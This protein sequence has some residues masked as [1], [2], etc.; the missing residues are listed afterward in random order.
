MKKVITIL[1]LAVL[2]CG[3]INAQEAAP[4]KKDMST[5]LKYKLTIDFISV[6]AGID[7]ES[8]AKIEEFIKSHPKKPAYTIKQ[9]GKE[10]ETKFL[11]RLN[12]LTK[13]EQS[14]FVADIK[15]L[16]TKPELVKISTTIITKMKPGTSE[17]V[18]PINNSY[19]LVMSFISKGGGIDKIHEKIME[20]VEKHPKKPAFET[21][22]WGR[23]GEVD[24]C[25]KLTELTAE[26]QKIFVKDIN[27]MIVDKEMVLVT[28]NQ[29]YVKKGR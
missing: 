9:K 1:A 10:G 3:N 27:K 13:A 22:R 16:I 6:G 2:V 28:E 29:E 26:E 7:A 11:L 19:R 5:K 15:K 18:S 14:T 17:S 4:I 12:E 8:Y 24:D 20:Y 23:E 25:F 21:H